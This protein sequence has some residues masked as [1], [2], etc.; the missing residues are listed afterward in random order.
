ALENKPI[1]IYGDGLNIR[2]WIYVLDHCRALDFVLQ[3]GK[4]GEVY[5]IAADQEKTNLELIHQLLDI[6]AE[7]ML[8]TS[9]LS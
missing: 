9:S 6:M 2:D 1:P 8:S 5:N 7:T 3:K 4:P